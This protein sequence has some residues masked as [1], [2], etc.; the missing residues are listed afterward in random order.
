MNVKKTEKIHLHWNHNDRILEYQWVGLA[1]P[2]APLM[3]FLHESLGSLTHWQQWPDYLCK[4]LGYR[5]L[6]Y[7]R[8]GHGNSTQRPP[9]EK[10]K[11]DY[12]HIEA[13][14]A[15]PALL[16]A[17]HINEPISLFGHSAGST[18]AL[19]YAAL[20]ENL[21]QQIIVVA[22]HIYMQADTIPGVKNTIS[23]YETGDLKKRLS[24]YHLNPDSVFWG[25]ATVWGN[26]SYLD[27]WNIEAEIKAIRCPILAIQGS[28]DEYASLAQVYDTQKN[29]P[30]TE[31][32]VV[33]DAKHS[34]HMERPEHISQVIK[35]FLHKHQTELRLESSRCTP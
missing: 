7:S 23:W 11:D 20:P 27:Q 3:V 22:P 25:W 1:D 30:Q 10:W 17:L 15:L 31:I 29:A 5:G 18:I 33:Q 14:Q 32:Y 19:L 34:P 12:L 9:Q 6:I 35:A 16:K 26:L 8:Y 2:N 24:Q 21:A 4:V 28:A 13:Q